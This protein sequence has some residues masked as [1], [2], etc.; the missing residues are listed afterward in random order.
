MDEKLPVSLRELCL[1]WV[2]PIHLPVLGFLP[3]VA[4]KRFRELRSVTLLLLFGR[5]EARLLCPAFEAAGI[6]PTII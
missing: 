3:Q 4:R 2:C 5:P 6:R 1:F